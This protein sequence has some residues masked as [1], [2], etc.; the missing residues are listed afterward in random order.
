MS[1]NKTLNWLWDCIASQSSFATK[2]EKHFMKIIAQKEE[3]LLKLLNKEETKLFQDYQE[4]VFELSLIDQE[5]GFT[6]GIKFATTYLI[7]SLK[8]EK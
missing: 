6:K 4:A 1:N 7:E 5:Q 8:E 2:E 3:D